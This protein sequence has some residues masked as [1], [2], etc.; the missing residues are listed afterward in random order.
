LYKIPHSVKCADSAPIYMK[1]GTEE[2]T[3][4]AVLCAKFLQ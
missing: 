4:G 3:T 1:C 2:H